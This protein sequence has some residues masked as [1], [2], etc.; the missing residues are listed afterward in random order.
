VARFVKRYLTVLEATGEAEVFAIEGAS[1]SSLLPAHYVDYMPQ[2]IIID[3]AAKAHVID[4]EWC[5]NAPLELAHLVFRSLL[6][7]CDGI[8]RF[9]RPAGGDKLTTFSFIEKTFETAGLK[10][11]QLDMDRY[12]K[13]ETNIQQ[14]VSGISTEAFFDMKKNKM[15]PTAMLS[16]ILQQ[17][18]LEILQLTAQ[19][20]AFR[21]SSSW[22]ITAPMRR[23]FAWFKNA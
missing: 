13:L 7:M 22:R 6:F 18:E 10:L 8:N 12:I 1:S 9:G 4:K 11:S 3:A 15:L 23:F 20:A 5:L 19:I 17:R 21:T 16:T 2:N 14:S